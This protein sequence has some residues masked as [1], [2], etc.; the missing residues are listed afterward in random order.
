MEEEG[1]NFSE[2]DVS[3]DDEDDVDVS[4]N[5]SQDLLANL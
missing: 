1:E 4:D 2:G 3:I 5:E